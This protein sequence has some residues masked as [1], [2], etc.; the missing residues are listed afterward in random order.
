MV[1]NPN[2][3][4]STENLS[5]SQPLLLSNNQALDASFGVDHY[6]FSNATANNGFH[7]QVTTPPFVDNPPSGNPPVTTANPIFFAFQ[8][9]ANLGVLQYSRGPNN[10]V[11]TPLTRIYSPSTPLSIGNNSSVTVF[12]FIGIALAHA[13]LTYSLRQTSGPVYNI[14]SYNVVY[15]TGPISSLNQL[16]SFAGINVFAQ[17]SGSIL[18][19]VSN[20]VGASTNLFWT[21]EFQRIQ[22]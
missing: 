16:G 5:D 15:Q 8:Q 7:N 18:S 19:L 13:T 6:K 17:F 22:T 4:I 9:T 11:I 20:F 21:L 3:P 14:F 10:A 1:F 12:D 2:R